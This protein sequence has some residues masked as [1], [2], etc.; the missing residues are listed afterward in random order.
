MTSPLNTLRLR[1][2]AMGMAKQMATLSKDPST[3]VGAVIVDQKRR[4]VSAGYNGFARGVVDSV[5]RMMDRD[6]KLRLTLHA[7]QNAVLFATAPLHGCTLVVTH[8]CCAQCA[9][10]AIQSGIKSVLWPRPSKEFL[11]RWQ[12]DYLLTLEQFREAEVSIQEVGS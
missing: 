11:S 9:A 2:W 4:L 7:E 1:V 10:V 12:S 6:T 3:K 8:P 5:D